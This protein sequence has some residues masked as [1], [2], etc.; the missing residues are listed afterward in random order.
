MNSYKQ[1]LVEAFF[2]AFLQTWGSQ[3]GACFR[4]S[5]IMVTNT[6]VVRLKNTNIYQLNVTIGPPDF[7]IYLKFCHLQSDLERIGKVWKSRYTE[8]KAATLACQDNPT[9]E[10]INL[11]LEKVKEFNTITELMTA[12]VRVL[13]ELRVQYHRLISKHKKQ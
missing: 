1:A 5:R 11:L 12:N 9:Q 3:S 4:K 6:E 7:S 10:N 2:P 13:N 8:S